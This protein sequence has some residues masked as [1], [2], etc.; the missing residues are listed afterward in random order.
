[1]ARRTILAL[2]S[3]AITIAKAEQRTAALHACAGH[4]RSVIQADLTA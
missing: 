2:F 1:M 3:G 4:L